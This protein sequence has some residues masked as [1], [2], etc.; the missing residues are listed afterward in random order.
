MLTE[1]GVELGSTVILFEGETK[2][3]TRGGQFGNSQSGSSA[4]DIR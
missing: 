1:R 4:F 3:I 2:A